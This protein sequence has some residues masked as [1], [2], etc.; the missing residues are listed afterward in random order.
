MSRIISS[1]NTEVDTPN[2]KKV[3]VS[4]DTAQNGSPWQFLANYGN[5]TDL[6]NAKAVELISCSITHTVPNISVSQG[7]NIFELQTTLG[8]FNLVVD[9]GFYSITSLI[10]VLLP[11]LN[12]FITPSV[13]AMSL[14]P[15]GR[16]HIEITAGP[17]QIRNTPNNS[18]GSL[19]GYTTLNA[20]TAN[21]IADVLPMLQGITYF[22]VV[23]NA[24][25]S[26]CIVNNP[27][28]SVINCCVFSVPVV[29]P[30]GYQ[31]V[32]ENSNNQERITF[33]GPFSLKSFDIQLRDDR[34][35]L[36]DDMDPRS[37]VEFILKVIY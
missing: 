34:G 32:F 1:Y 23:S 10:N 29:V 2:T 8:L 17:A 27:N 14:Y 37:K 5:N 33:R 31:N 4:F 16:F 26:Y 22:H 12:A 25:N 15:D 19:L 35:R 6:D 30:Y 24:I 20:F 3:R 11:P 18:I 7:N 13:A 21:L 28:N 36:L 9:D